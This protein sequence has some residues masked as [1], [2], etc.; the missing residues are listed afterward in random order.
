MTGLSGAARRVVGRGS[1]WALLLVGCARAAAAPATPSHDAPVPADEPRAELA[2]AL[3]LA[4]APDCEERF[5]LALYVEPGVELVAWDGRTGRC[6]DRRATIRYYPRRLDRDA[7]LGRVRELAVT[8]R[9]V[10]APG[11][12]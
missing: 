7:L 12:E 11:T 3:E 2:V 9:P 8:A 10:E 4:P 1:G 6:E 5:D